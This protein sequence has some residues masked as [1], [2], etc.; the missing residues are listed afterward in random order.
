MQEDCFEYWGELNNL[1]LNVK[2]TK[3]LLVGNRNKLDRL[4]PYR[5]IRLYNVDV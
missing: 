5:P 1:H 2:K 4:K 3:M